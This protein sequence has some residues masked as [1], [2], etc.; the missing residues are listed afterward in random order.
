MN[1]L[2][3]LAQIIEEDN[4][5]KEKLLYFVNSSIYEVWDS[6]RY[7]EYRFQNDRRKHYTISIDN[8]KYVEKILQ[9]AKEGA[10]IDDLI[11]VIIKFDSDIGFMDA[12]EFIIEL[13]Q[14]QIL[15]SEIVP[16]VSGGD[17]F[18]KIISPLP[19][20]LE[21]AEKIKENINDLDKFNKEEKRSFEEIYEESS[22][23]LTFFKKDYNKKHLFQTDLFLTFEECSISSSV[24]EDIT[25][26]IDVLKKLTRKNENN[27]LKKF[28][29]DFYNRYEEEEV[30]LAIALD[31]ETGIGYGSTTK[32][33]YDVS[34]LID[35][36]NLYKSGTDDNAEADKIKWTSIDEL[37]HSKFIKSLEN[38]EKEI[39][40][41]DK[42]LNSIHD[43]NNDNLPHTFSVMCS[44]FYQ[45]KDSHKIL[46]DSVGG[47]SAT[48][49]I[50]RFGNGDD[51]ILSLLKE[52]AEKE[53]K[54]NAIFAEIVHLPEA[55]TGNILHRPVIR[56]YEIPYLATSCLP[57]ENQININDI[58]ITIRNNK[59][60]LKS[61]KLDK[62]IIPKL[63][64][65]HNYS[66]NSLPIY[67][68][69][70]DLQSQDSCR[71]LS[72]SWGELLRNQ[73]YLPRLNYGNLILAQA[74]WVLDTTDLKSLKNIENVKNVFK[75]RDLP[76]KVLLADGDNELLIDL[77]NDLSL[78]MFI[79]VIKK[80][81]G[82]VL[83]KEFLFSETNSFVSGGGEAFANE[84]IFSFF[85]KND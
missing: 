17:N 2:C 14:N 12:K 55:R 50:G 9:R 82:P 3:Q 38:N 45:V 25:K 31:V 35:D 8:S 46:M 19:K 16:T 40:L 26:G 53:K 22:D 18:D 54:E 23:L 72:F 74:Q 30:P 29:N 28:K 4:E 41:S 80:R 78:S 83:L 24:V 49:L 5:T 48:Y 61:K 47:D 10:K 42:D 70:C 76:N 1:Y 34:P 11:N 59:I 64:N 37:L 57:L 69:L 71:S 75:N 77:D 58:Y 15:I 65:A 60:L 73:K 51:E 81:K 44:I 52:I 39:F 68:F 32:G 84:F 21:W 63:S 79:S 7:V 43:S 36:L 6:L 67:F 56:E 20:Y 66:Y 62:E 85:N 33:L 13:I 27:R